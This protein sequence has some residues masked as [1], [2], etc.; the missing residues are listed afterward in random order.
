MILATLDVTSLYTNI[1]NQDGINAVADKLR[2]DPT[3]FG[4]STYILDL[5]KLVLHNMYFSFN[6]EHSLQIGCTAMD[7]SVAPSF[8]NLFMDKFETKTIK[9]TN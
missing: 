5:L 4:I 9:G 1:P 6:G 2:S 8:A 7:T 3:K